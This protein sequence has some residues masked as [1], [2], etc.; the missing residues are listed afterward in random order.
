VEGHT[1]ADGR[2]YIL[3]LQRC[4]PPESPFDTPHLSHS[5]TRVFYHMLRPEFLQL[6]KQRGFPPL[7]SDALTGWSLVRWRLILYDAS[8]FVHLFRLVHLVRPAVPRAGS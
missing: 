7:S 2:F 5:E 1:G 6:L 8:L 4:F 3:D